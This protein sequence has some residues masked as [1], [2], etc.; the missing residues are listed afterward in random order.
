MYRDSAGQGREMASLKEGTNGVDEGESRAAQGGGKDETR[1]GSLGLI[2]SV[3]EEEEIRE[4][5]SN[6]YI[7]IEQH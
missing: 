1:T 2:C 6:R 4:T 5:D 3:V 7:T